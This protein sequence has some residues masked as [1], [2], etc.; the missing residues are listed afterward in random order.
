MRLIP[1][2]EKD[3]NVDDENT[4]SEFIEAVPGSDFVTPVWMHKHKPEAILK[5]AG[6]AKNRNHAGER[7]SWDRPEGTHHRR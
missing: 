5:Q 2:L 1:Q 4:Q 3:L 7:D 6:F